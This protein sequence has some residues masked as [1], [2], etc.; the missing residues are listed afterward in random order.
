MKRIFV[1]SVSLITL[2]IFMNACGEP[3]VVDKT[4]ICHTSSDCPQDQLCVNYFAVSFIHGNM[5]TYPDPVVA[6]SKILGISNPDDYYHGICWGADEINPYE[7][8]IEVCDNGKDD[9]G[10]GRIDCDDPTCINHFSRACRDKGYGTS[11]SCTLFAPEAE[12]YTLNPEYNQLD[13]GELCVA[14]SIPLI[15]E[16]LW[17][18]DDANMYGIP[19]RI[20]TGDADYQGLEHTFM[21]NNGRSFISCGPGCKPAIFSPSTGSPGY[22]ISY[23]TCNGQQVDDWEW[24]DGIKIRGDINCKYFGYNSGQLKCNDDCT[25]DF[26][27]CASYSPDQPGTC[28]VNDSPRC[29]S[30][31]LGEPSHWAMECI[32]QNPGE[33]IW[34]PV[35]DCNLS[36]DKPLCSE[37]CGGAVQCSSGETRCGQLS[38]FE[39]EYE[40]YMCN[41]VGTWDY[42]LNCYEDSSAPGCEMCLVTCTPDEEGCG[43]QMDPTLSPTGWYMCRA[44]G[45]FEFQFDCTD[46][47]DPICAANNYCSQQSNTC[48]DGTWDPGEECDGGTIAPGAS[49]ASISA[50]Y[51]AGI[52]SC[53]DNCK[54]IVGSCLDQGDDY[55]GMGILYDNEWCKYDASTG[56]QIAVFG[57]VPCSAFHGGE[58]TDADLPD[59]GMDSTGTFCA[60][61]AP[62]DTQVQGCPAPTSDHPACLDGWPDTHCSNRY[63]DGKNWEEPEGF[64]MRCEPNAAT[65]Y[66]V[67]T[68]SHRCGEGQRCIDGSCEAIET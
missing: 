64:V 39:P 29:S 46:S 44:D 14:Q 3:A 36:P 41:E 37:T 54:L 34:K 21:L 10:D 55:C 4:Y 35:A 33:R 19:Y 13:S 59:C 58:I 52:P 27:A 68:I 63:F 15:D 2:L 11:S 32:E 16:P 9:D 24:C 20:N 8:A 66:I 61:V 31:I 25:L 22:S 43:Y 47:T 50:D 62:D 26:S 42:L 28:S 18:P 1:S 67:R 30:T 65:N 60:P 57:S 23:S 48:G 51:S 53:D 5:V 6:S 40:L 56:E 7:I 12:P 38:L 17:V 49:C 45:F